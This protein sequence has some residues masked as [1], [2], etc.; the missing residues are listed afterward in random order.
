[1]KRSTNVDKWK[2]SWFIRLEPFDKLVFLYVVDN[3]DEAGFCE[4]DSKLMSHVIGMTP[5]Q[6]VNSVVNIKKCYVSLLDKEGKLMPKIWI[7]NFLFHQDTLPLDANNQDHKNIKLILEKN[8]HFLKEKEDAELIINDFKPAKKK[9]TK[10]KTFVQ[11][12]VEDLKE[13]LAT[14]DGGDTIIAEEQIDYWVSSGWKVGTKPMS[15][16]KATVR[17]QIRRVG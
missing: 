2:D 17:N 13:Y 5:K 16:W 7:K 15:D 8:L 3:C 6:I 14:I 11:P 10:K 1:M 12:T 9:T 4:L